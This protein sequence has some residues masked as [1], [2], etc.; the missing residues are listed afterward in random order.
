MCKLAPKCANL[1]QNVQ[2]CSKM[3]KPFLCVFFRVSSICM[4]FILFWDKKYIDM[5]SKI[6]KKIPPKCAKISPKCAK[7]SPKCAKFLQNVQTNFKCFFMSHPFC[8]QFVG[9]KSVCP[10]K[11]AISSKMRKLL[12]LFNYR[13]CHFI[14]IIVLY[15]YYFSCFSYCRQ[16]ILVWLKKCVCLPKSVL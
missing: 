16:N 10:P 6:G 7:F 13:I 14:L 12:L 8:T 2:N 3:C 1:L 4:Q 5:S 15:C 9:G 11:C